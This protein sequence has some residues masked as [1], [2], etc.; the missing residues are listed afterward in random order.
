M[1]VLAVDSVA[2]FTWQI[3]TCMILVKCSRASINFRRHNAARQTPTVD[4]LLLAGYSSP[5][6]LIRVTLSVSVRLCLS[7]GQWSSVIASPAAYKRAT[8]CNNI[9]AGRLRYRLVDDFC[10]GGGWVSWG[11]ISLGKIQN[12]TRQTKTCYSISHHPVYYF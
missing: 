4:V 12:F 3:R 8:R 1:V 9:R 7:G 5:S 2:N 10:H 6:T 11:R